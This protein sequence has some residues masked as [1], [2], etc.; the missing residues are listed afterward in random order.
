MDVC[1]DG[2]GQPVISRS[3]DNVYVTALGGD[4]VPGG[5]FIDAI[6]TYIVGDG[7]LSFRSDVSGL[8]FVE[9]H[10]RKVASTPAGAGVVERLALKT[11]IL[12]RLLTAVP[13]QSYCCGG[14]SSCGLLLRRVC[15]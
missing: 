12:M 14:E 10:F 9:A 6:V 3:V 15:S 13:A 5:E 1:R 8:T 4:D 2:D 7:F 11:P